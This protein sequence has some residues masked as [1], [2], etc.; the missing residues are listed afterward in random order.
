MTAEELNII[1]SKQ[2]SLWKK[3]VAL[4]EPDVDY[5][6]ISGIQVSFS[7]RRRTSTLLNQRC[8]DAVYQGTTSVVPKRFIVVGLQPLLL[9]PIC[10]LLGSTDF[11]N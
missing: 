1:V 7:K 2:E 11:L 6:K 8:A 3:I 5:R 10:C 9:L 4:P